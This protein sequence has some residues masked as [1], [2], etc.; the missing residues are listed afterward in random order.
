M[1]YTKI[2]CVHYCFF[3]HAGAK[4]EESV[5]PKY[6]VVPKMWSPTTNMISAAS[7]GLDLD[8]MNLIV[9]ITEMG[10]MHSLTVA[11]DHQ[12]E[13]LP[14]RTKLTLVPAETG[15]AV[16]KLKTFEHKKT[17]SRR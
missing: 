13:S 8:T 9:G 16:V 4:H 17:T 10:V 3:T 11:N 12:N 6:K 14:V 2:S 5:V 15:D 7:V 1:V